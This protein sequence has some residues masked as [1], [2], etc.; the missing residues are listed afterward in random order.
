MAIVLF[1]LQTCSQI[2]F[3]YGQARILSWWRWGPSR[4]S[5]AWKPLW[6]PGPPPGPRW[7]SGRGSSSRGTSGPEIS[8]GWETYCQFM[9]LNS[10]KGLGW[11][12]GAIWIECKL[13]FKCANYKIR[14]KHLSSLIIHNS[15]WWGASI[16]MF[17]FLQRRY[18][19]CPG[20][21]NCQTQSL[22]SLGVVWRC[23]ATP[24]QPSGYKISESWENR[25][26]T[27]CILLT[28]TGSW[29]MLTSCLS[30]T[31]HLRI[32]F[33]ISNLMFDIWTT[34]S[35]LPVNLT[36]KCLKRIQ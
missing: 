26:W 14:C 32:K 22:S 7:R 30:L 18:P 21:R 31:P 36:L 3:L 2:W 19:L 27:F 33:Y 1:C 23:G 15:T 5:R 10:S 28:W 11:I 9:A 12:N 17:E 8:S 6:S 4:R 13:V 29:S 24:S 25:N 20:E 16:Q 35:Q 34:S